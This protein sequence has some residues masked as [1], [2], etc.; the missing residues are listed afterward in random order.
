MKV[1]WMNK[2]EDHDYD[3]ARDYLSLLWGSMRGAAYAEDL[4]NQNG[5]TK[6]FKAK[7]IIR[8]SKE[9][10]L[11]AD[12]KHVAKDIDKVKDG[13]PLSPVLLI[14]GSFNKHPLVIADGYHRVCASYLLDENEE[15]PAVIVSA[16]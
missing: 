3:A 14:A 8:A 13:K 2:P 11:P 16:E 10:L 12:N 5:R 9:A 7:D 1:T 6:I 15:V 4:R